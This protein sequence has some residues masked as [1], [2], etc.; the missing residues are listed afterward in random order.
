M[1]NNKKSLI[2]MRDEEH[3]GGLFYDFQK[4]KRQLKED[5]AQYESADTNISEESNDILTF[6]EFKEELRG[7]NEILKIPFDTL[8]VVEQN[9]R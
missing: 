5:I 7:I 4:I 3:G 9:R 8:I 1:I 2:F 6:I